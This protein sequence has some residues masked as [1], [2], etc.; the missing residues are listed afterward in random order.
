MKYTKYGDVVVVNKDFGIAMDNLEAGFYTVSRDP[1]GN[2]FLSKGD[3]SGVPDTLYGETEDRAEHIIRTYHRRAERNANTGILLSGTKGS[4]K[5]MLAKVISRHL[6]EEEGIPIIMVTQAYSDANFIEMMSKITD[7]AVIIFD[8]FDKTYEKK[9]DQEA[10]LTLLDGTG[11][12]NKLFILTKNSGYISEFFLNRPSRVFYNFNY[13]KISIETMMDYLDRNLNDKVHLDSF[14][15][16]WDVSVELSFDV[17]Q[18]IVEELNFYPDMKFKEALDMMGIAFGNNAKWKIGSIS[19]N[20]KI[21]HDDWVEGLYQFN[22]MK[23]FAGHQQLE[24]AFKEVKD[25]DKDIVGACTAL[26]TDRDGDFRLTIDGT[27]YKVDFIEGGKL[28]V[29][30]D[31]PGDTFRVVIEQEGMVSGSF[32]K[33]F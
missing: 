15:R 27:K 16:L 26:E 25:A 9:Q 4:G 29:S 18:G 31:K 11:S 8:E 10:L 30:Q 17:I 12:G 2:Y 22:P 13:D 28:V 14:Q 3:I 6:V 23:F 20:G 21:C 24:I 1:L 7:K 33:L 5:T 32:S 19:V